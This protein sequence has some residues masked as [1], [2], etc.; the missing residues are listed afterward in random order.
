MEHVAIAPGDVYVSAYQCHSSHRTNQPAILYMAMSL[1]TFPGLPTDIGRRIFELSASWD[2][3]TARQLVLVSKTARKWINPLLYRVVQLI[4]GNEYEAFILSIQSRLRDDPNFIA[5]NVTYLCLRCNPGDYIP[6]TS[7]QFILLHC[8]GVRYLASYLPTPHMEYSLA[9]RYDYLTLYQVDA[10][11]EAFISPTTTHLR[12]P[13]RPWEGIPHDTFMRNLFET[14]PRLTHLLLEM[15]V[16]WDEA[17]LPWWADELL[18]ELLDTAPSSFHVL[19]IDLDGPE[20]VNDEYRGFPEAQTTTLDSSVSDFVESVNDPR[21]VAISSNIR[22]VNVKS[23][24]YF[25]RSGRKQWP[26]GDLEAWRIAEQRL[27]SMECCVE[28]EEDTRNGD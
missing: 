21:V 19:V 6:L 15:T 2:P 17:L 22:F 10:H 3:S 20:N 5:R 25:E 27:T 16:E 7:V 23:S 12:I 26:E 1:S 13:F 4:E 28:V 11:N 24:T 18:H 8:T 9:L 14:C